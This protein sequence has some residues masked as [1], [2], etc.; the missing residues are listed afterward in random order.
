MD[1]TT[2]FKNAMEEA[3]TLPAQSN[4]VLLQFY[5]LYKQATEGDNTSERPTNFFD[6]AGIAKYNAWESVK[7]L[8]KE[9]AM[10]KYCNLVAEL[11]NK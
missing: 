1:L 5:A 11:K 7:G 2:M 3:K 10:Q 6:I 8:S 9:D 4:E